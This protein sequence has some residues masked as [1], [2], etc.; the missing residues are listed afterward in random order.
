MQAPDGI[1]NST[2]YKSSYQRYKHLSNTFTTWLLSTYET[3]NTARRGPSKHPDTSSSRP[4]KKPLKTTVADLEG[5]AKAIVSSPNHG[6]TKVPRSIL[7]CLYK[8]IQRRSEAHVYYSCRSD[9]D[10]ASN[11]SHAHFIGILERIFDTLGGETWLDEQIKIREDQVKKM[12]RMAD[13]NCAASNPPSVSPNRFFEL[14]ST[15]SEAEEE[16]ESDVDE[17]PSWSSQQS[18]SSDTKPSKGR[19]RRSSATAKQSRK[20]YADKYANINLGGDDSDEWFTRFC[21]LDDLNMLRAHVRR[22]W[23]EWAASPTLKGLVVAATATDVAVKM[24]ESLEIKMVGEMLNPSFMSSMDAKELQASLDAFEDMVR[25]SEDW[26]LHFMEPYHQVLAEAAAENSATPCTT[27]TVSQARRIAP[28]FQTWGEKPLDESAMRLVRRH[29][30]SQFMERVTSHAFDDPLLSAGESTLTQLARSGVR[31]PTPSIPRLRQLTESEEE[32]FNNSDEPQQVNSTI[33]VHSHVKP[34]LL[35]AS[36]LYLDISAITLN[37]DFPYQESVALLGK[38]IYKY[39]SWLSCQT[40]KKHV[41]SFAL[42]PTM[43]L[44]PIDDDI[45]AISERRTHASKSLA[46]RGVWQEGMGDF[47]RLVGIRIAQDVSFEFSKT[48]VALASPKADICLSPWTWGSRAT[49]LLT[50]SLRYGARTYNEGGMFIAVAHVYNAMRET[51][52]DIP[53]WPQMEGF[54]HIHGSDVF[55]GNRPTTSQA[56]SNAEFFYNRWRLRM[57]LPV[58]EFSKG[59]RT[60][61]FSKRGKWSSRS[62]NACSGSQLANPD[63]LG[64]A[65]ALKRPKLGTG[66]NLEGI[67]KEVLASRLVERGMH[68]D[69]DAFKLLSPL[70]RDLR[71]ADLRAVSNAMENRL[72]EDMDKLSKNLF[73]MEAFCQRVIERV[74]ISIPPDLLREFLASC[75]LMPYEDE[76]SATF[77]R[78]EV[79]ENLPAFAALVLLFLWNYHPL[80]SVWAQVLIAVANENVDTDMALLDDDVAVETVKDGARVEEID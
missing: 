37:I 12:Q 43:V 13:T 11:K 52:L 30:W 62:S 49:H 36:Q 7:D 46:S 53:A 21:F 69:T 72:R 35:F 34:C 63:A 38:K 6:L 60:G 18:S 24:A 70:T 25:A 58:R 14:H 32:C 76:D 79:R 55:N 1:A 78:W 22:L 77:P 29:H 27:M 59:K 5:F 31:A 20:R 33:V 9:S 45:P 44:S 57:G 39:M 56:D 71:G 54:L 15:C 66:R 28:P 68:L 48:A 50:E 80:C 10:L 17:Q 75:G 3:I 41:T 74:V 2:T 19:R 64:P 8:I 73:A 26:T 67:S 47:G 40:L 23:S 16:F 65:L 4:P 42:T 51:Q 61:Q